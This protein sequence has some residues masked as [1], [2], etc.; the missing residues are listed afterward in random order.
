M[1]FICDIKPNCGVL[2]F[3][4]CGDAVALPVE[5]A[6]ARCNNYCAAFEADEKCV[7]QCVK[8]FETCHKSAS[9]LDKSFRFLHCLSL[10]EKIEES[11][12]V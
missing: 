5:Q 7:R 12:K 6:P 2:C 8:R 3:V 11:I 10:S 1:H 4:A 9:S